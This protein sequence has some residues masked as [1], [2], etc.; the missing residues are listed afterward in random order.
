MWKYG[1]Y[2]KSEEIDHDKLKVHKFM[3]RS[4]I[5]ENPKHWPIQISRRIFLDSVR[6]I[7]HCAL[8]HVYLCKISMTALSEVSHS[9]FDTNHTTKLELIFIW[10]P[11]SVDNEH[12]SFWV[13][14]L[15]IKSCVFFDQFSK[16]R[17]K[18]FHCFEDWQLI[19]V[20]IPSKIFKEK[21]LVH[22]C[23]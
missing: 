3:C 19:H 12:T 21:L 9:L 2:G 10:L 1:K 8:F 13:E 23:V 5:Y 7:M 17:K 22:A 14:R 20:G 4:L 16:T 15:K 11:S 18:Y 6:R